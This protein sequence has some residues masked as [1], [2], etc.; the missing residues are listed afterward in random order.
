M[1]FFMVGVSECFECGIKEGEVKLVYS[2]D[3]SY[4]M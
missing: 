2:Q 4:F 1:T 3:D